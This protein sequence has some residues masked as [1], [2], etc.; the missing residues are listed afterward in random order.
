LKQKVRVDLDGALHG[1]TNNRVAGF[2]IKGR[3]M[4]DERETRYIPEIK[5]TT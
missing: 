2:L 4:R 3:G 5:S 1:K